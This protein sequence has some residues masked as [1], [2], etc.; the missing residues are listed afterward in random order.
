MVSLL[1]PSKN[2]AAY[3]MVVNPYGFIKMLSAYSLPKGCTFV[4]IDVV[5]DPNALLHFLVQNNFGLLVDA[6]GSHVVNVK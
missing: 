1:G 2:I 4:S 3:A 5:V 6:L